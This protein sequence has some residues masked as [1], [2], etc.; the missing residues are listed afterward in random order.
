MS[1]QELREDRYNK[2]RAIGQ[3]AFIQHINEIQ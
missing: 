3:F 1:E 2:Y